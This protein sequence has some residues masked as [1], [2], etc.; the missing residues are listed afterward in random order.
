[1]ETIENKM[2]E[3]LLAFERE[4]LTKLEAIEALESLARELLSFSSYTLNL[5]AK[6]HSEVKATKGGN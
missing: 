5:I 6:A 2:N 1:M 3:I 4:E